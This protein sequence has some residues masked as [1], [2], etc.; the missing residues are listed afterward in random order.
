MFSYEIILSIFKTGVF[1]KNRRNLFFTALIS[2]LFLVIALFVV[3]GCNSAELE[4]LSKKIE[5]TETAKGALEEDLLNSNSEIE[6][7]Q[8]QLNQLEEDINSLKTAYH[9]IAFIVGADGKPLQGAKIM[10]PDTEEEFIA[11]EDGALSLANIP[12]ES[13]KLSAYAQG[14]YPKEESVTLKQGLN[15][16]LISMD[17][18]P[19]GLLPSEV[20]MEGETLLYLEDF[21]DGM[22]QGWPEIEAKQGGWVVEADPTEEG[23]ILLVASE[24]T[25]AQVRFQ[26]ENNP[27]QVF[28]NAVWRIK[29]KYTGSSLSLFL[30]KLNIEN[31][32]INH[33]IMFGKNNGIGRPLDMSV[34]APEKWH[35][36]EI[37]T[38]NGKIELW[39]DGKMIDSYDV[40][41]PI[42]A[43]TI[44]LA[45]HGDENAGIFYYDNI[46][47]CELSAP[48]KSIFTSE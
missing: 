24:P 22:A 18:D 36:V 29:T 5:E 37:S 47:V 28:D 15:G 1:M 3:T 32:D 48:F 8:N 20:C 45:F 14:Y 7:L 30:W 27:T 13:I 38:F 2:I 19:F 23:N 16:V 25:G 35:I 4:S 46:S 11:N 12:N 21:Q 17:R 44:G 26:D 9:L 10:L 43:G 6:G 34:P 42:S 40:E 39:I 31:S 41:E 33:G